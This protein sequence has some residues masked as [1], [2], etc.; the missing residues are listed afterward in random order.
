MTQIFTITD[1]TT[2]IDFVG[3]NSN[4]LLANYETGLNQWKSGGIFAG[5]ELTEGS[6]PVFRQYDNFEEKLTVHIKGTSQDNAIDNLRSL[7]TIL[8]SGVEYFVSGL[9]TQVYM[10]LKSNDETN[11]RYAVISSYKIETLP[12]LFDSYFEVGGTQA[13]ANV[14]TLIN[15][16]EII[17]TRGLW[18][19]AAPG[20]QTRAYQDS[21]TTF[22]SINFGVSASNTVETFASD[23]RTESNITHIFTFDT[24]SGTYSSNL[25]NS[26]SYDLFPNPIGAGDILYIGTQTSVSN[27]GPFFSLVFN[28]GVAAASNFSGVFEYNTSFG[29]EAGGLPNWITLFRSE[30][31]KA[32]GWSDTAGLWQT[33]AVNGVTGYWVRFRYTSG[34]G[35]PTQTGQRVYAAGIPYVDIQTTGLAGDVDALSLINL[36]RYS[37][38][39]ENKLVI[40]RRLY[41][42]GASFTSHINYSDDQNPSGITVNGVSLGTFV[43][44][45]RSP[46]A[47]ALAVTVGSS[48]PSTNGN[49]LINNTLSASFVGKFR[50]FARVLRMS[51]NPGDVIAR[52]KVGSSATTTQ[53]L[54]PEVELNSYPA[55]TM[56]VLDLGV[57]ELPASFSKATTPYDITID[58]GFMDT[59]ASGTIIVRCIDLILIPADESII[60]IDPQNS[61]GADYTIVLD[62]ITSPQEPVDIKFN[63]LDQLVM[64]PLYGGSDGISLARAR[65]RL[66]FFGYSRVDNG[67]ATNT[68]YNE[69]VHFVYGVEVF[70]L[71][72]YLLPRGSS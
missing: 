68:Y 57:I 47:R 6:I 65:Q 31:V 44:D 14:D 48:F 34:S 15:D 64:K 39:S 38:S 11:T 10:V 49:I 70:K 72:R 9:G 59:T 56:E 37:I 36:N 55:Q 46:T 12:R 53:V 67:L 18:L 3:A 35:N 8:D 42:R 43:D 41:S 29:F 51:G 62:K 66:W 16:L 19:E 2:S 60:E 5:S 20:T 52:L 23:I 63:Y 28:I 7:L 32:I 58:I 69:G 40:G 54:Y 26:T 33:T 13:A 25:V 24:S 45:V 50:A 21:Q 1:G 22:N 17:I 4:Y 71:N 30:G 27:S 61:N